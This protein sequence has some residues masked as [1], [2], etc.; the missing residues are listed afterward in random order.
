MIVTTFIPVGSFD[1]Y[2]DWYEHAVK[3]HK[4]DFTVATVHFCHECSRNFLALDADSPDFPTQTF[5]S[6]L[7]ED[8][9]ASLAFCSKKCRNRRRNRTGAA[10]KQRRQLELAA[11]AEKKAAEDAQRAEN[12]PSKGKVI[13]LSP[14]PS[15]EI[16]KL[17]EKTKQQSKSINNQVDHEQYIAETYRGK[18]KVD[19]E[20]HTVHSRSSVSSYKRRKADMAYEANRQ[21]MQ[22]DAE[23]KAQKAKGIPVKVSALKQFGS[24]CPKPHKLIHKSFSTAWD[25]IFENHA[26]DVTIH[27]Y[28]CECGSVHIG[29]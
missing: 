9:R 26:E 3:M 8:G 25:F 7:T 27:P 19:V 2:E 16:S 4:R 12:K 15:S 29:H 24:G 22:K 18:A 11:E 6:Q 10:R 28:N 1:L 13:S 20:V 14:T 17:V 5:G 21:R 23:T